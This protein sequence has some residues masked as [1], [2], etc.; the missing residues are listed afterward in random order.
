MSRFLA[1]SLVFLVLV[2]ALFQF[3]L[4]ALGWLP[5]GAPASP[6][7]RVQL[8]AWGLEALGLAALFLLIH[9]EES[10]VWFSGV[11]S[12]WIAWV[13]R[14]PLLVVTVAA[15]GLDPKPFWAMTFRWWI[16]YT[17]C[18]IV[19]ATLARP[20]TRPTRLIRAETLPDTGPNAPPV[21]RPEPQVLPPQDFEGPAA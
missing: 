16:L 7:P 14:G 3:G 5:A 2:M 15:A 19:L 20:D 18:G 12:G 21:T 6:P 10:S 4:A 9:R 11:L 8:G 1:L 13:F 17:V